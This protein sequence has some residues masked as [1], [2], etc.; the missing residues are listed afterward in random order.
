MTWRQLQE[1]RAYFDYI[2]T[3]RW[4][5]DTIARA[6][7]SVAAAIAGGKTPKE[8]DFVP[9]VRPDRDGDD[10]DARLSALADQLQK[11]FA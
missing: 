9:L 6:V 2:G 4:Q 10:L 11:H 7:F 3:E 8:L 5:T 1:W